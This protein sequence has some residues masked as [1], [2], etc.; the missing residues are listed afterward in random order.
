MQR[1]LEFEKFSISVWEQFIRNMHEKACLI[2]KGAWRQAVQPPSFSEAPVGCY[3]K[4]S[5]S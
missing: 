3:E 1:L 5:V 2:E 4:E